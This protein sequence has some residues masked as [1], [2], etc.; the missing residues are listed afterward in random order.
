[1]HYTYW[2]IRQNLLFSIHLMW[3]LYSASHHWPFPTSTIRSTTQPFPTTN[4]PANICASQN[5]GREGTKGV[6][7]VLCTRNWWNIRATSG[8]C[9]RRLTL[10]FSIAPCPMLTIRRRQKFSKNANATISVPTLNL[11][12][13]VSKRII[14]ITV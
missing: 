5:I 1:M 14:I 6:A 4:W 2:V 7:V 10:G 12:W 13:L 11:T 9:A 3:K 8:Q